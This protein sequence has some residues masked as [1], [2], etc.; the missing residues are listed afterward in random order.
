MARYRDRLAAITYPDMGDWPEFTRLTAQHGDLQAR[1]RAAAE[2]ADRL[3]RSRD[4]A[5]EADREAYAEALLDGQ[6][7]PGQA[8]TQAHD[9]AA[10][11]KRRECEALRVAVQ[12][13]EDAI[14]DLLEAEG[15]ARVEAL[16]A[17]ADADRRKAQAAMSKLATL[18]GSVQETKAQVAWV[19]RSLRDGRPTSYKGGAAATTGYME[20]LKGPNGYDH[21]LEAVFAALDRALQPPAPVEPRRPGRHVPP[22][23]QNWGAVGAALTSGGG[24]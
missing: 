18:L 14:Q 13:T 7:D 15:Q 3:D 9:K 2:E 1:Y 22:D 21:T 11:D 5:L 19:R 4:H 16:T 10:A 20:G 8:H 12:R 24:A 23:Q 17:Q 6:D